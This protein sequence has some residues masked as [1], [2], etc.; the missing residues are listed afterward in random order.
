MQHIIKDNS[1]GSELGDT[2]TGYQNLFNYF[3]YDDGTPDA[4]Y[5]LTPAGSM[6]AY[7]F[8]LN[9]P[10]TLRAI[11]MY[12]NNVLNHAN[13]Q[14]FFLCVWNDDVGTPGDTIYS[15]FTLPMYSEQLILYLPYSST[16][17]KRNNLHRVD[18]NHGRQSQSRI[19]QL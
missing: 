5:G 7:R 14:Y 15:Q 4:S 6:L 10:D 16:S 18:T 2:I 19:R 17:G 3:A 9:K 12:F 13:E 8:N 1:P 11:Q